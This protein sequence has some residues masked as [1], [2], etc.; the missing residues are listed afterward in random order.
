MERI[1]LNST[2]YS[3]INAALNQINY[4]FK[5]ARIADNPKFIGMGACPTNYDLSWCSSTDA[6]LETAKILQEEI[7]QAIEMTELLR[8]L[9]LEVSY[10]L[11]S[12]QI[13]RDEYLEATNNI[14]NGIKSGNK[15]QILN[16]LTK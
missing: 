7:K 6:S 10:M 14:Y 9:N 1:I 3:T 4:E 13:T 12:E 2:R 5:Y 8:S 11:D 16:E 15:E